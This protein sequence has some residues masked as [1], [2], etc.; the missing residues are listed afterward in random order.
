MHEQ[1]VR[2]KGKILIAERI[3]R[4][5]AT[6]L[7]LPCEYD[8]LNANILPNR[9]ILSTLRA[10]LRADE[11]DGTIRR[12]LLE[13]LPEWSAFDPLRLSRRLFRRVQLHR[14]MRHYRFALDVC[15]LLHAQ[16][17]PNEGTGERRFR[18]F[19]RDDARMGALFE[20]FV[21]NFYRREQDRFRVSAPLVKWALNP[22]K[23]TES[24]ISFLPEMRTDIVLSDGLDR[25]IID[26]KFYRSAF[27][28][29]RD[30]R[31][32]ISG[33]LYQLFAYVKNQEVVEGWER[34]RGM[35][36]Y[37]TN[38]ETINEHVS[39]HGHEF[40]IAS[41]NLNQEWRNIGADLLGLTQSPI[42]RQ[43]TMRSNRENR[44]LP[45]PD[46]QP[47]HEGRLS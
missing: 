2:P 38:G 19:Q 29:Y 27:Q 8:E 9:I 24:G 39:L 5:Q 10:V 46:D 17:L 26:C 34:V 47:S 40:R 16:F 12:E 20:A 36:L 41:I 7:A 1:R 14:N 33:H 11:L 25:W 32:F 37:P 4:P 35:L 22:E 3:R 43:T 6:S 45:V 23:S 13:L 18:D 21:R 15:R 30:V 44:P 28:S 42:A 31:K